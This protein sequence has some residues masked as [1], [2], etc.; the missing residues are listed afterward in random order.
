MLWTELFSPAAGDALPVPDLC[1]WRR[2]S[3]TA[4]SATPVRH[5]LHQVDH[6]QAR[7]KERNHLARAYAHLFPQQD[8]FD[9]GSLQNRLIGIGQPFAPFRD[10]VARMMAFSHVHSLRASPRPR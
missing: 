9:D 7:V 8:Q 3:V 4:I 5:V 1:A 2:P 6:T 10:D